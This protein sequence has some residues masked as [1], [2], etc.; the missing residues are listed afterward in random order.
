MHDRRGAHRRHQERS[1]RCEAPACSLVDHKLIRSRLL[2]SCTSTST[3]VA[4]ESVVG[5]RG[6]NSKIKIYVTD[7]V[8]PIQ[9]M[10]SDR[11][12][13]LGRRF[14]LSVTGLRLFRSVDFGVTYD[15]RCVGTPTACGG[16]VRRF[17]GGTR[18]CSNRTGTAVDVR[19]SSDRFCARYPI[20]RYISGT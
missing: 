9:Y 18:L 2:T 5:L 16:R 6:V 13:V 8:M 10:L 12:S 20:S 11:V 14:C 4:S 15:Y 19:T 3:S 17:A 7:C 1:R